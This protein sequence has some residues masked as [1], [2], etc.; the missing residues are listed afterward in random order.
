MRPVIDTAPSLPRARHAGTTGAAVPNGI[1][2]YLVAPLLLLLL[3]LPALRALGALGVAPLAS[4]QGT[5]RYALALMFVFTGAA[6]FT[7]KRE[8]LVRMVPGW[9]PL[10]GLAVTATGLL[11][12]LGAAGLLVPALAPLAGRGLALLLIALFPANVHAAR[13][14]IDLDGKPATPLLFRAPVQLLFIGLLLWAT[15]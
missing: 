1:R 15:W 13:A 4:W 9:M 6:H 7:R 10:P 12:F 5:A 11:Q 8:S 14:G 3:A 2:P